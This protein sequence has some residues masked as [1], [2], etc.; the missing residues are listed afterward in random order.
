MP[1]NCI[2][3][4]A[5]HRGECIT[6]MGTAAHDDGFIDMLRIKRPAGDCNVKL[7]TPDQHHR[8]SDRINLDAVASA[9]KGFT[10]VYFT[11]GDHDK[12]FNVSVKE[13]AA[14]LAVG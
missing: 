11:V 10:T 6:L 2:D 1:P 14:G 9:S 4:T 13:L 3:V 7:E 8:D 12:L 5:Q